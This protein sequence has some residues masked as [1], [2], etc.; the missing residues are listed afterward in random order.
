M[1]SLHAHADLIVLYFLM[2]A[3][4]RRTHD[5]VPSS[6]GLINYHWLIMVNNDHVYI[7]G[8]ASSEFLS[9]SINQRIMQI[10]DTCTNGIQ[11]NPTVGVK[12]SSL[13]SRCPLSAVL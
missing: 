12:M 6:E 11:D 8:T 3:V 2:D 7:T 4:R 9:S 13:V 10:Q 5:E 1:Q